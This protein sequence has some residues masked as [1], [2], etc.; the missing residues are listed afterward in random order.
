MPEK[1]IDQMISAFAA[2][3]LDKENF[4]QFKKY[5]QNRGGLP[6]GELGVQQNVVSL[7]PTIPELEKP[8]ERVKELVAKKIIEIQQKSKK[9]KTSEAVP[10]PP[11][12]KNTG[13]E[14]PSGPV[15]E[16]KKPAELKKKSLHDSDGPRAASAGPDKTKATAEAKAIG[17]IIPW[18]L[19][20][21]ML[22]ALIIATFYFMKMTSELQEQVT[23][24][25][26]QLAAFQSEMAGTKSFIGNNQDLID[27]FNYPD[28]R[29]VNLLP[30]SRNSKASG[31]L[32]I[33]FESGEGLLQLKH[34]PAL[35]G[36]EVYQVWMVSKDVTLPLGAVTNNLNGKYYKFSDIP[37][38][39]ERDINLFRVTKESGPDVAVPEGTAYLYGM[40]L[41]E[42]ARNR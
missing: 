1:A 37:Y 19:V 9:D 22:I 7:I 35:E 23:E 4:V 41:T 33:S 29:I 18:I 10:E 30:I 38:L 34:M 13:K 5:V 11:V 21:I 14:I 31:R 42:T 15:R 40:F 36:G 8:D 20:F 24:V 26:D 2:G 3:S 27:F 6:K 32:L 16:N 39:P 17:S 25:K 12:E 28:V